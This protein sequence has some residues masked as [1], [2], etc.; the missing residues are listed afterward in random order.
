MFKKFLIAI[1]GF[2]L[3]VLLLGA[4][5][6]KQIA[7]MSAIS[8]TPPPSAVATIPAQT[9]H[10]HASLNSI[11]TLAP[12]QG[13]TL[14]ADADGTIIRILADSGTAV[15]AGDILIELDTTV[16][17]AQLA[18]AQA[19]ADLS[20]INYER[21][22]DLFDRNA[23]SKSEYDVADAT[24]KQS[25]AEVAALTATIAKKQVRAPFDGRVGIRLVNVGQYIARGQPM[26]PLQKLDSVYVNFSIPQ[27]QLPAIAIGQEV[28]IL[29][30]AFPDRRFAATVTAINAEVDAA[31]RNIA[32]QATMANP[33]EVL[34]AG[35]FARVEVQMTDAE[36]QVVVPATAISYASYGNSVFVVEKMKD[37]A[38]KEYLGV[39][40]QF[41][42]LGAA[43]GDLV[44]VS[45]GLKAGEQVVT[46][47][48]FKLRNGAAVQVNNTV[49]PTSSA[50]PT[51]SN[52]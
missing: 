48:V 38:G 45:G 13:V 35:M 25:V 29:V 37:E 22:K 19:R 52:T 50:T 11:G 21:A 23:T 10:W 51:P 43:R 40:Q 39:R 18:A 15:K 41:V 49:Q 30:D 6:A 26:L 36:P 9:A 17:A 27:R 33:G 24:L 2:V 5:K 31:T 8:H 4:V 16:E 34:R 7:D 47:G 12:V 14:A 42:K 46:S 44:A 32:V 3:V 20:R 28:G 1:A